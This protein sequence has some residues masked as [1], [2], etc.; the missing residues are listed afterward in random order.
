LFWIHGT[1]TQFGISA[2]LAPGFGINAYIQTATHTTHPRTGP[3]TG[4]HPSTAI[5][6]SALLGSLPAGTDLNT[7]IADLDDRLTD[8]ENQA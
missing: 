1:G 7:V 2:I 5:V 3:H 4:T 8:L 6:T